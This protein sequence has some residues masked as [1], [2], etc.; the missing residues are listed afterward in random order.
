MMTSQSHSG[1]SHSILIVLDAVIIQIVL[2]GREEALPERPR[3]SLN[4]ES[5]N[6]Y[7]VIINLYLPGE[8]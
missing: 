8:G 1:K 4:F 3:F 7:R 6:L 5:V 2:F